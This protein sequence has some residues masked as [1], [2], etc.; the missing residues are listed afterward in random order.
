MMVSGIYISMKGVGKQPLKRL[1][2]A[3]M[4]IWFA[5]ILM[6]LR[7]SIILLCVT[8]LLMMLVNPLIEAAEQTVL[9]KI[10]PFSKQGRVFGFSQT[11]ENMVAPLVTI[12]IGPLAHFLFIPF[13][14]EGGRGAELIGSWFGTGTGRGIGLLFLTGSLLGFLVSIIAFR[15]PAYTR[16]N[17]EYNR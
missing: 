2:Q 11:A 6:P 9:Q 16:V 17:Q 7:E 12:G 10:V 13:M 8:L 3:N 14:Q 15:S 5:C 1:F 4:F